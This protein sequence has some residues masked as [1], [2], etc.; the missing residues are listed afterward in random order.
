MKEVGAFGVFKGQ[1]GNLFFTYNQSAL[2]KNYYYAAGKLTAWSLVH[3]GPGLRS[4]HPALFKMMCGLD[5]DLQNFQCEVLPDRDVL[6]KFLKVHF[7]TLTFF[8]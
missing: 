6:E 2:D 8:C 5:A 1:E 7:F 4:L 3:D